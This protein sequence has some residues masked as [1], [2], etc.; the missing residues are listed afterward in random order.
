MDEQKQFYRIN[1]KCVNCGHEEIQREIL[2]GYFVHDEI[3][4]NCCT[5]SLRKSF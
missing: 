3:C 1:V 4:I 2:K 5:K